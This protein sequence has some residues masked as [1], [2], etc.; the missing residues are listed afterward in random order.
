MENRCDG[1]C[2]YGANEEPVSRQGNRPLFELRHL[3]DMLERQEAAKHN[4]E[5]SE[6]KKSSGAKP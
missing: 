4:A 3:L 1:V 2:S 5:E 6:E